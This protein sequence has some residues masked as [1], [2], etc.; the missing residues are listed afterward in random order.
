[1]KIELKHYLAVAASFYI[2]ATQAVLFFGMIVGAFV[3]YLIFAEE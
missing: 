3:I 1:M 2:L